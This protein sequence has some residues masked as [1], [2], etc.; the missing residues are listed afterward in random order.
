MF[1]GAMYELQEDRKKESLLGYQ[2]IEIF[3][4]VLYH[5]RTITT[6]EDDSQDY[7]EQ[8]THTAYDYLLYCAADYKDTCEIMENDLSEEVMSGIYKYRNRRDGG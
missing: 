4:R 6:K 1:I 8:V 5:T 2:T 7:R 3:E